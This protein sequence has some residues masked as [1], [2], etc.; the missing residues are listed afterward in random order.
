[1][2]RDYSD[3]EILA[4]KAT[5][6]I[7]KQTESILQQARAR[8]FADKITQ[9]ESERIDLLAKQ[10]KGWAGTTPLERLRAGFI[11]GQ[12]STE[13][14]YLNNLANEISSREAQIQALEESLS[15]K[16][17]GSSLPFALGGNVTPFG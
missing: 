2:L 1:V 4:G 14:A 15:G 10:E 11:P 17:A 9:L 12:N 3:E 8:A 5:A 7:K 13:E 6:A 16:K